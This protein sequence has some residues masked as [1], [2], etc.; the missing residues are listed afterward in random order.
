ML[1]S[2]PAD[3]LVLVLTISVAVGDFAN[4]CQIMIDQVRLVLRRPPRLALTFV[5]R[6]SSH[7]G[8][9]SGSN[10]PVS[11]CR[12]LTDSTA[13][14]PSTLL[15]VSS[16]SCSCATTTR[17]FTLRLRSWRGS[18]RIATCSWSTLPFLPT[19]CTHSFPSF[20]CT[21]RLTRVSS[22]ALRRQIHRDYRKPFVPSPPRF[23]VDSLLTVQTQV[24][25]LL[26]QEP[27]TTPS[28]S[29]DAR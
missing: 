4:G 15:R 19:S 17:S 10:D 2:Y 5:C 6:S 16:D 18:T 27:S 11:S 22:H 7:L 20:P 29:L 12:F 3:P 1:S 23:V 21:A 14:D 24:D 28:S 13:K 9:R 25:R 26:L 8:R